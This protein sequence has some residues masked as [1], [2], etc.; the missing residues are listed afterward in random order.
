VIVDLAAESGGNV[1][2]VVAGESTVIHGVT[3]IGAR[4][5]TSD[6]ATDA[7]ALFARNH[8]NFLAAFW[9]KDAG[10]PVLDEEIGTAIRLTQGGK[11]IHPRLLEA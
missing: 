5:I 3:V 7:S 1:E 2:G 10:K 4:N 9:D 6:L 8:Y 11:I